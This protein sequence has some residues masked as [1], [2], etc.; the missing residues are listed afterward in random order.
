MKKGGA[1]LKWRRHLHMVED[2]Q[3]YKWRGGGDNTATPGTFFVVC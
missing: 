1:F 2:A 3:I